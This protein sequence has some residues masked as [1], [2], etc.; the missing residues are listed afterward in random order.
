MSLDRVMLKGVLLP[1]I[2]NPYW[3]DRVDPNNEL[4]LFLLDVSTV[5]AKLGFVLNGGISQG[6]LMGFGDVMDKDKP[7]AV[8][9]WSS[10]DSDRL[11]VVGCP[12]SVVDDQGDTAEIVVWWRGLFDRY[13]QQESRD[14]SIQ[15][16]VDALQR[17]V[18]N[19]TV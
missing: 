19:V 8:D 18:E 12:M 5:L 1:R 15:V 2:T 9:F 3:S 17:K 11:S 7:S 10:G 13:V 6:W 16:V 4:D 14:R